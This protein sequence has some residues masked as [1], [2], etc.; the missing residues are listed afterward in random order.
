MVDEESLSGT[1]RTWAADYV[2]KEERRAWLR[3]AWRWRQNSVDASDI[4]LFYEDLAKD[5]EAAQL[6]WE[7]FMGA[8]F[9][10]L[11][12]AEF[13][14][15]QP[16]IERCQRA[17]ARLLSLLLATL[18]A[19]RR[20][21]GRLGFGVACWPWPDDV[22]LPKRRTLGPWLPPPGTQNFYCPANATGALVPAG[23]AA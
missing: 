5:P 3:W 1:Q 15:W 11:P 13:L 22:E 6:H 14:A 23:G 9:E 19:A 18:G 21:L 10:D 4:A 16:A 8:R 7:V 20:G 12:G 17:D 2:R